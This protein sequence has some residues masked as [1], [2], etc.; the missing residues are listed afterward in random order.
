MQ[1]WFILI[2]RGKN[3]TERDP[4]RVGRSESAAAAAA[5]HWFCYVSKINYLIVRGLQYTFFSPSLNH[6]L[7]AWLTSFISPYYG[8][9]VESLVVK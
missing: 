3:K 6:F 9:S 8:E 7:L 5:L 2:W 1:M 4:G